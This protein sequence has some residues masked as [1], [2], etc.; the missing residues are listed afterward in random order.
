[1]PNIS[2]T[3]KRATEILRNSGIAEPNREAKSL[4]T[5]ALGKDKTFLIAY[6]E[7]ELNEKEEDVF[8]A[9]LERR[10]R[11]EPFQQ[12]AGRQEFW[13]LDFIVTPDVMIPRPE[14]ELIVEA[15]IEILQKRENPRFCEVGIGSGCIS[16]SILH[17]EKDASAIGLDIS[18]KA[19]RIAKK[20]A[21][22]SGVSDRLEFRISD[23]FGNL[24]GGEKFDLI[25]SNPPY[26]PGVD[27]ASLQAEV[28]DFDPHV[29]L[30]DGKDGLSIIGK[31][32]NESPKF[33]KPSGFLLMEFGFNQ[34]EKVREMFL[35]EIWKWVEFF[36]DLQGIPRM[37]KAEKY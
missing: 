6:P 21:E 13:G 9:Y 27:V 3:I 10:S 24:D 14:T 15:G 31:L 19:L 32:I 4:L 5:L 11:H 36:P 12:I 22:K 16:V 23:V 2:E 28:R 35:P 20:N 25:V 8:S 33:L 18:E 30:T 29:A 26:V 37:V 34:S 1:M 7:Y 17:E